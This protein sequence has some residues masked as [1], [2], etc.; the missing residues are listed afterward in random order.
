MQSLSNSVVD[1]VGKISSSAKTSNKTHRISRIEAAKVNPR[2]STPAHSV[3][4]HSDNSA[5]TREDQENNSILNRKDRSLPATI[6]QDQ[7]TTKLQQQLQEVPTKAGLNRS[8]RIT[9]S[10]MGVMAIIIAIDTNNNSNLPSH[11][12]AKFIQRV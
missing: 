5:K 6:Q 10:K 4:D 7:T 8:T 3:E 11:I 1:L 9:T 2:I 12:L